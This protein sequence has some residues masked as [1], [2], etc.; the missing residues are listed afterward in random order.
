MAQENE[1]NTAREPH[2]DLQEK[3][4]PPEGQ[5]QEW[6][7]NKQNKIG[8]SMEA[9]KVLEGTR[10]VAAAAVFITDGRDKDPRGGH[11]NKRT[12]QRSK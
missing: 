3:G 7:A 2:G 6:R 1:V 11:T 9:G 8:C 4:Q 5:G 10:G 12:G